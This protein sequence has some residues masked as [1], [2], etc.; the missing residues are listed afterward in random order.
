M[1]AMRPGACYRPIFCHGVTDHFAALCHQQPSMNIVRLL[2]T[3][4]ETHDATVETKAHPLQ[5]PFPTKQD[6]ERKYHMDIDQ[7][8][9]VKIK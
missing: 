4:L 5:P 9:Q 3:K 2:F 7:K 1:T 8:G 6:L